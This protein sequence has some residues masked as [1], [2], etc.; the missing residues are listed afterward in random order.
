MRPCPSKIQLADGGWAPLHDRVKS[1]FVVP[2]FPLVSLYFVAPHGGDGGDDGIYVLLAA[3]I[4]GATVLVH[5]V[6]V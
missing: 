6:E 1:A 4:V 3:M 2:A 5:A